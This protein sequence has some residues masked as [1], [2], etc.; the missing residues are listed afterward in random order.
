MAVICIAHD[1]VRK[2]QPPDG[3]PYDYSALKLH[4]KAAALVEE[5]ADIIGHASLKTSVRKDDLGFKKTHSRAISLDKR[6]LHVGQNPAYVSGNRF[7]LPNEL[8]LEWA[9][10]QEALADIAA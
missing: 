10:L 5:W 6:V 2:L 3:E 8:P 7:G 4:K 1:E 9:A